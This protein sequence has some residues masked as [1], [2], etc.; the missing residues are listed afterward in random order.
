MPEQGRLLVTGDARDGDARTALAA[1]VGL[2]VDRGRRFDFGQHGARDA[3]HGEDVFV[4]LQLVDVEQHGARGIGIVGHVHAALGHVPDQ[5]GVDGAEQQLPLLRLFTGAGHVVQ[6]P[7]DLGAGEIGVQQQAGIFPHVF[8]K[9]FVLAQLVADLRGTA[10][11]P[12]D[13]IVHGLA[14][15]L[16][17][18][19]RGLALVGDADGRHFVRRDAH[20]GQG[21]G[22][23]GALGGPNLAGIMLHPARTGVDLGE[24]ALH[25]SHDVDVLIQHDGAGT[26]GTLVQGNDIFA[27]HSFFLQ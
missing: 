8:L 25:H 12:D 9:A 1:D 16:F 21:F 14:R 19:H 6:D 22:Q 2:A 3:Q 5:P 10:A 18:D 15:I 17:P 20:A 13:G 11:L 26:G 7:L 23:R 4:P 24:L 27:L